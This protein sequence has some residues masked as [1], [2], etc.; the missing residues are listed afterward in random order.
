MREEI[1]ERARKNLLCYCALMNPAY[2]VPDHVLELAKILHEVESGK[3]RRVIVTMP[4]RHGKSM[5]DSQYFPAWYLGRN[6]DKFII[7]A[8]YGQ[9]LASDFGRKVRDQV[10]DPLFTKTFP[11]CVMKDDT[12]AAHRFSTTAGGEYYAVGVGGAITGRGAHL[13]LIDDPLKGRE[14]ADSKIV[15]DKVNE[16]YGAVAYTR[17]MPNASV[18][19]LM[20]RWHEED[21]VGYVTK[22]TKEQWEI[23]DFP[24]ILDEGTDHEEALWPERYPLE[25]LKTIRGNLPFYD[26]SCLYQQNP[27]PKGGTIIE[28][29][30]LN[31]GLPEKEDV[32]AYV[33][34]VDPA[35]SKKETADETSFAVWAIGYGNPAPVYEIENRFGRFNFA[36]QVSISEELNLQYKPMMFGIEGDRGGKIL[37]E[38]LTSKGLPAVELPITGDKV[39]RTNSVLNY[40]TQGRVHVNCEKTRKQMLSFR[41]IDG[42]EDDLHDASINALRV[43]KAYTSDKFDKPNDRYKGL[44]PRSAAFWRDHYNETITRDNGGDHLLNNL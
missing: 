26:W 22:S 7:T 6:P 21:L 11:R 20:T 30:W 4:P 15:R 16:W 33:I 40:F 1:L 18:I 38:V 9:D 5:L 3:T 2:E 27:I 34:G 37:F 39:L 32:A 44:D 17:L 41:G 31:R 13:F 8:T 28:E 12:S 36:E 42:D 14:E 19:I 24:A 29:E 23:I 25:V 43:V 10:R 35:I